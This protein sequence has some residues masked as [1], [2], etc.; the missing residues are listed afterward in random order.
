MIEEILD[1]HFTDIK[2]VFEPVFTQMTEKQRDEMFLIFGEDQ[3]T[4]NEIEHLIETSSSDAFDDGREEGYE[5][6]YEEG[7]NDAKQESEDY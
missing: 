3:R 5:D 7:Y 2:D 1:L 4:E 6:G